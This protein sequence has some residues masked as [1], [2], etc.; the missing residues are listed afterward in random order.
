MARIITKELAARILKKLKATKIGS[1]GAHID[2]EI[3]DFHGRIIAITSLRRGSNKELGHDHMPD[4]LHIGPG[5]AKLL[6]QC[7]LSRKQYIKILQDKG[8]AEPDPK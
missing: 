3:V 1:G 2:Y 4:D 7:P 5:K 6:G 8:D